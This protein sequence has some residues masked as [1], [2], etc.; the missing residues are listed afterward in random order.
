MMSQVADGT[1]PGARA[2]SDT[3]GGGT[4]CPG[5]QP[6]VHRSEPALTALMLLP[7]GLIVLLGFNAGGYF[8]AAPPVVAVVL[9][10]ILLLRIMKSPTPFEGLAPATLVA[11]GALAL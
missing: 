2:V 8:P 3:Q 10:Q 4:P 7:G 1:A 11:I 5:E 9:A 6:E